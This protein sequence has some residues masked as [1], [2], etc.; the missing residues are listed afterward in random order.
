MQRMKYH[1]NNTYATNPL[2]LSL[3]LA[4]LDDLLPELAKHRGLVQR[5]LR[6]LQRKPDL[7]DVLAE[8]IY[9]ADSQPAVVM[10]TSPLL[11]AAYSVDIDCI[12]VLKFSALFVSKYRLEVKSKLVTINTYMRRDSYQSDLIPGPRRELNWTGFH[13]VIADSVSDDV[14]RIADRKAEINQSTWEYVY[15]LGKE[16]CLDCPGIYRDGRPFLSRKPLFSA[17]RNDRAN[18]NKQQA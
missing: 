2:S 18:E 1:D 11:I 5:L 17:G 15:A 6:S 7:L 13:P 12:A 10:Q 9:Y 14:Q 8:H 3:S 16:Y 4:K